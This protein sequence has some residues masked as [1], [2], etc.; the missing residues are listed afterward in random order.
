METPYLGVYFGSLLVEL[1]PSL[2]VRFPTR[3]NAAWVT[4]RHLWSF[5]LRAL[6]ISP[7]KIIS[8]IGALELESVAPGDRRRRLLCPSSAQPA[9]HARRG[10]RRD[11][12]GPSP[13]KSSLHVPGKIISSFGALEFE[14]VA[15]GDRRR[16]LLCPLVSTVS[17]KCAHLNT[18]SRDCCNASV[19][20][21]KPCE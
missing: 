6:P 9:T 10:S 20:T 1:R 12:C 16:T 14:S 13:P 8:T 4:H 3:V 2:D 11:T 15:P 7:R 21:P 19:R 17:H 5:S 18:H